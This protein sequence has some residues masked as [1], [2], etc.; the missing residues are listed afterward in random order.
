MAKKIAADKGID[1]AHV[2]GSGDNGRIVKRDV[3]NYQPVAIPTSTPTT[4]VE[5]LAPAAATPVVLPVGQEG[6][7]EVKN[8][9][10]RKV[11]AKRLG[12]SKF[13]HHITI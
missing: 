4:S 6:T 2:N 13:L 1:L 5:N 3:E 7:E 11:I 9:T 10:M 12:E 8:S